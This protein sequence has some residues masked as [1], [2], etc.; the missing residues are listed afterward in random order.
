MKHWIN[1][2]PATE[3]LIPISET[4]CAAVTPYYDSESN[5]TLHARWAEFPAWKIPPPQ[6]SENQWT[7]DNHLGNTP[8]GYPA[9]FNWTVPGDLISERCAVRLRY[10][11][12][13]GDY[14]GFKDDASVE[15]SAV[16]EKMNKPT[17]NTQANNVIPAKVDVYSDYGF[18]YADVATS[19]DSTKNNPGTG[20]TSLNP[21]REYVLKN[22]PQVDVFGDLAGTLAGG[23]KL[24]F[25]L[26]I[27][28]AQFGRT[29]QDR[30]HRFA[31]RQVPAA[32]AGKR[33]HN[34]Q[35][36]GK[37][38][39]IVQTFPGVEYD[40]VPQHLMASVG[41]YI[42]FQWTGSNT[43]PNNNAGQGTAGT[44]RSNVVML[45]GP[46]FNGMSVPD[47]VPKT[48]GVYAA[49][50]PSNIVK[51]TPFLGL[52]FDD[53][54]ALATT[55]MPGGQFGG[56]LAQMND[57]GTYFDLGPRALAVE[58]IWHYMC[59]RNNAFTNRGQKGKIVV[60][61]GAVN[62][63]L[64]GW[65]GGDV[66]VGGTRVSVGK[67]ALKTLTAITASSLPNI[68]GATLSDPDSNFVT[69]SPTNL[70]SSLAS[71]DKYVTLTIPFQ[72][73]P[74]SSPQVMHSTDPQSGNWR[75]V[76]TA[77][78]SD[79]VASVD[80]QSGGVYAVRAG[81]NWG[82]VAGVIIAVVFVVGLITW[83]TVRYY[84][85]Y[86]LE[87]RQAKMVEVSG[88]PMSHI[89]PGPAVASPTK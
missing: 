28:T 42:H 1:T 21:S 85:K 30:S 56:S 67:A 6:C 23:L 46:K 78:F 55:Q 70:A 10:N 38:G 62:T 9:N 4:G 87:R 86:K 49:N 77:T 19:F 54:Y 83:L 50:Y 63:S 37:R 29:F 17:P 88:L 59:T 35:V 66:Q 51:D 45:A 43:N 68:S 2:K 44:D 33:I 69:L 14:P 34:V 3:S 40:F 65:N 12:S 57:A 81:T 36:R 80:V 89:V 75:P 24:K 60:L 79:G 31:I 25:Q 7:R 72:D 20:A 15:N 5:V 18:V 26:A 71:P 47:T 11:I 16:D 22:N 27:N 64:I 58:G 13:T 48:Y 39:N 53:L 74:L 8:N 76:S 84:R 73:Q 32:L 61:N 41:D 52:S 82:A